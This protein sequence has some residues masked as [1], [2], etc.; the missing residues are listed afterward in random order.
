ME[1]NYLGEELCDDCLD[2]NNIGG[3][4]SLVIGLMWRLTQPDSSGVLE[5][6]WFPLSTTLVLSHTISLFSIIIRWS[7]KFELN[8]LNT[9]EWREQQ[10]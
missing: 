3:A 9:T 1:R 2:C 7:E 10:R 6:L 5:T 8:T 4:A